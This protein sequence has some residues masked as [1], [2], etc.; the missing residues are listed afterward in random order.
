MPQ[1]LD[2]WQKRLEA[3]F[4][5]LAST[6]SARDFPVFAL[7]HGLDAEEME[8]LSGLLRERVQSNLWL[9]AHWLSWVVYA[10]EFGYA[11]EGDEYWPTF[12]WRTPRWRENGSRNQL[13][14]WFTKFHKI[15]CGVRPSGV[16]A[17]QFPIIAWPITHAV[18]PKYLQWQLSKALY[19]L[20]YE[21]AGL[22]TLSP[23]SVGHLLAENAWD[24]SSRLRV[25]LQQEELTGRIVLALLGDSQDVKSPLHPP[26]LSRLV[27][28]LEEVQSSREWLKETS[29]F[30]ADR[31]QG[32]S[33]STAPSTTEA[34]E[35]SRKS[36]ERLTLGMRPSLMLRRSG[37]D[38]WSVVLDIP[39][40]A[41]IAKLKAEM[42]SFLGR[43]RCKIAGAAETWRPAGWLLS[44]NQKCLLKSWP[45]A[46]AVLMRFERENPMLDHLIDS[47]VRL[48]RGPTWLCR[49]A[50]DGLAHEIE[51]RTVRPNRKYIVFGEVPLPASNM[52]AD[53]TVDCQ[54]LKAAVL[55]TPSAFSTESV[56]LLES[57]GLHVARTVRVWPAGLAARAWD[58][59][60]YS[61][62]LTTE[63]P[64]FGIA[65]DYPLE[66]YA[67]RLDDSSE[68][69]I[70]ADAKGHPSYVTLP[71]LSRGRHTLSV[72]ARQ[73]AG[74]MPRLPVPLDGTVSLE[75]R[76]PATWV[77]GTTSHAGLTVSVE[78]Y[79]PSLDD[80]WG[81]AVSLDILGPAGRQVE[82]RM[83]LQGSGDKEL[84]NEPI[85]AFELPVSRD[86]WKARLAQF[87]SSDKRIF[88]FLEASTGQLTISGD[89][90][91]EY[92]LRL[93][94][95]LKPVRW[96]CRG[97][98]GVLTLR[99]IDDTGRDEPA[100][101]TFHSFERPARVAPW[102][103]SLALSGFDVSGA[104]GLFDARNGEFS[105]NLVVST[106]QIKGGLQGLV[107]EPV[108]S[109]LDGAAIVQILELIRFWSEARLM[110]PLVQ[111]RHNRIV[112]RLINRF[113]SRVCGTHWAET[114][115]ACMSGPASDSG[116]HELQRS[117]GASGFAA[118]LR[119]DYVRLQAGTGP[120]T[121]W[122]ADVAQR[123]RICSEK[124]LCEFA[125]QLASRPQY[126]LA[127]P[128]PAFDSLLTDVQKNSVLMRGAR[129]VAFLAARDENEALKTG[130]PGWT[131]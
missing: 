27:A 93:D 92:T 32:A 23:E 15:Y 1:T 34:E 29:R 76:E 89:E 39:S 68:V 129:F 49:V 121:L 97:N 78:P 80:L 117:V 104:G 98:H 16:W 130:L 2:Q 19:D 122:F 59:E 126:M 5:G 88:A 99:L 91:G 9:S 103:V 119:R 79:D 22:H 96:Q 110:G 51:S 114:E 31:L 81:E 118:V 10:T 90:L 106:P 86:A 101:V 13:R 85:G 65:H 72:R 95:D 30:V 60:G 21:L 12:E 120:G 37:P 53:C 46:G 62:W 35:P 44:H 125:L 107:I 41:G 48:S 20:R 75:V 28:D 56:Q 69:F 61:E 73:I 113:F 105:E 74:R 63:S 40:F 52:L 112:T 77:P 57:L 131:W 109:D 7:E 26:T 33:R 36:K 18:L 94:R 38:T 58:G 82:C 127:I 66:G 14:T 8:E 71:K 123:Y 24:S 11:Y 116:L 128:G 102:E 115:T 55:S 111:L 4:A 83:R 54:G 17:G 70:K 3:H 64:C 50:E 6:R 108:L 43:T 25:F 67:L 87:V 100:V 124:G 84:L 45:G 47:E 42:R